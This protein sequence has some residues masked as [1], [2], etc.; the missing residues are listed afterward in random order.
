MGLPAK[1]R[2]RGA[3]LPSFL[4]NVERLHSSGGLLHR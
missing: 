4:Q 2:K 1:G 3:G